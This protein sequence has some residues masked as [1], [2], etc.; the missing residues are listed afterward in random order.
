LPIR[1]SNAGKKAKGGGGKH[2]GKGDGKM[3]KTHQPLIKN[4]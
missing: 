2:N 3:E 4:F 1:V